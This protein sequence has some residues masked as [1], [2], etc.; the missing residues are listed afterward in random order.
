MWKA[1]GMVIATLLLALCA[2][3]IT[4][5][6]MASTVWAGAAFLLVIVYRTLICSR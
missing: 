1:F 3:I 4:G 2:W 6:L 5:D